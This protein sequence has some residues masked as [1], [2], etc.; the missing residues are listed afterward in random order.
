MR[1][2]FSLLAGLALCALAVPATASDLVSPG[3]SI[4]SRAQL[5]A[6][7]AAY[8]TLSSGDRVV[9]DGLS[10]DLYDGAN[11]YIR[12][13]ALLPSFVFASF[14]EA[15]P[16][17]S[18]VLVGESLNGDLF[19][20]HLDGSGMSTL[21]TLAFNYDAVFDSPTSALVSAATCGFGCGNDI[22]RVD[23]TSGALSFVA[24][25]P[26]SA[27]PL[28][29]RADG[30]LL[31]ATVS[32]QFPPP[33]GSTD[34]VAWSASAL[35]SGLLLGLS[36]ATLFHGGLD[37]AASL[38]VDP[39]FGS[40][41]LAESRFG[42]TSTVLEF[43]P[44][45]ARVGAVVRSSNFLSNLELRSGGGP[46][47]FHA[48][49]PQSGVFLHYTNG[50]LVTVRPARPQASLVT[51]GPS[52]TLELAGAPANGSMLVLWAT[53]AGFD[54]GESAH[55]LFPDFLFV[56]GIPLPQIRRAGALVPIDAG[57]SASWPIAFLPAQHGASLVF[58]ALVLDR[59]GTR[60][61]GASNAA[62]L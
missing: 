61:V 24:N 39:V 44:A 33:P 59:T 2:S 5:P 15:D 62:L 34:I 55:A 10:V 43:H 4:T 50:D 35:S 6:P 49:Q 29:M 8:H 52:T 12:N 54:P 26:G 31:Y 30:A 48:Y 9:F 18:Y 27:G 7:F 16:S 13:L 21:A 23:T 47:H 20:V 14:V 41:F 58:Q 1:M 36:D 3:F 42:A 22:A 56:S 19:R 40:V 32:D 17:E 46:G 53:Q 45:G 38:A 51:V 57:G 28:A 37:G 25:V 60:F 11:N